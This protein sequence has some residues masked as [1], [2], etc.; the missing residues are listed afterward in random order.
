MEITFEVSV[1]S[2]RAVN[3]QKLQILAEFS[4]IEYQNSFNRE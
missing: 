1:M 3:F 2:H 4:N